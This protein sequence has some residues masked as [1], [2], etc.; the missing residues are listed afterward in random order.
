V[1]NDGIFLKLSYPPGVGIGYLKKKSYPCK[2]VKLL[3][4]IGVGIITSQGR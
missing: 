3:W 2:W 1:S 4:V